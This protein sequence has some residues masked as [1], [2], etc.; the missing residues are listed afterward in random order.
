MHATR[1]EKALQAATRAHEA[2]TQREVAQARRELLEDKALEIATLRKEWADQKAA[3]L[4]R[5][6]GAESIWAALESGAVALVKATWLVSQ[7]M[8]DAVLPR[9]QELP[10]EAFMSVAELKAQYKQGNRDGVLPVIAISFCWD[11]PPHPDPTGAQLKT[12]A[13]MLK[14]EM[15]K[16]ARPSGSFE[17][18]TD[19][20]VF[21]DWV[22]RCCP[23]HA[24]HCHAARRAHC[25][26]R[27]PLAPN[28]CS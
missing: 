22:R 2:D 18:F 7:A 14:T 17:G 9:R 1:A 3:E 6:T 12:V 5:Y 15:P 27:L 13:A 28:L 19:M 11:T 8:A 25:S 21:W 16:Y 4:E 20:G 26:H 10:K 23:S 24:P